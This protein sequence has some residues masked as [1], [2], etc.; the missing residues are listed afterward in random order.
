MRDLGDHNYEMLGWL[1]AREAK[2]RFPL[3]T[4]FGDP[5]HFADQS[6]LSDPN[7]LLLWIAA[8]RFKETAPGA[9]H[10]LPLDELAPVV[11]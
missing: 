9:G 10:Y 1:F 11:E 6:S 4:K 2:G 8:T 7:S 5:A 3:I